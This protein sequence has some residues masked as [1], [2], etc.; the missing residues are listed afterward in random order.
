M[1][2]ERKELDK[3][4]LQRAEAA[5]NKLGEAEKVGLIAQVATD[6]AFMIV[7]MLSQISGKARTTA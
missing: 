7:E 5:G 1:T 3:A 2:E 4:E 6:T